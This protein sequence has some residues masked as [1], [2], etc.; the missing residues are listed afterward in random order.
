VIHR[1]LSTIAVFKV[2]G[3]DTRALVGTYLVEALGQGALGSVLGVVVGLGVSALLGP[4]LQ[5][6]VPFEIQ[7]RLAWLPILRGLAMGVVTT[8]LAA[9]WPVLEVRAVRPAGILRGPV[10]SGPA[11][12]PARLP[13][14]ALMAGLAALAFWQARSV[15]VGAIFVGA[16][17][18][19]LVLLGL[20]GRALT[21]AARRLPRLRALVLRQ[22]IA[23]LCRPGTQAVPVVVALGLGV[24]LVVTVALLERSLA[25]EFQHER[26]REA[27]SFFFIDIQPDQAEGFRQ[28]VE[29]RSPDRRPPVLTPVVRARLGAINGRSVG[30]VRDDAWYLTREYVLT[31]QAAPPA[32]NVI[33]KGRWW[34]EGEARERP[35]V[36]VEE[37]VARLLGVDVGGTVTF[38]VQGVPVEAEVASLRRVDWQSLTLNFFMILSPGALDGAP[39]SYVATA[40]VPRGGESALQDALSA[41]FPNVT[42]IPVGEVL[43]RALGVMGQIAVA[44]RVVA[45]CVVGAGVVVMA[46][47]LATSRAQRLYESVLLRSLGATRAT[48]ARVFAVEYLC[49]GLVAGLGGTA[50]AAVAAWT[51]LRFV[52]EVPWTFEPVVLAAGP[53]TAAALALAVGGLGTFRLLAEPPLAVLRRE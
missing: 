51:V 3:A 22:G 5:A 12:R 25:R 18:L 36:S 4:V 16:S 28:A 26:R 30:R 10:E 2:L 37:E 31:Y 13:A 7:A 1:R 17:A 21:R 52:L 8:L 29:R 46:G 23:N 42:A 32:A 27:P 40:R 9:L 41:A 19:A 44:I 49:L 24:M 11:G 33:V 43:E 47:A 14:L 39:L 15:Q 38:D 45:L 53:L 34:T 20:L 6:F 48:V 35:R 50:L